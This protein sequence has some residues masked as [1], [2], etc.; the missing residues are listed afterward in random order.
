MSAIS[1]IPDQPAARVHAQLRRSLA[2]MDDTHQCAVLWF[3]EVMNRD[4]YR[5]LGHSSIN[6]YA[7]QELGFSKSKVGDFIRLATQLDRLPAVR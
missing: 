6:Q 1:Y 5:D 2:A 4:L 3:G 7:D